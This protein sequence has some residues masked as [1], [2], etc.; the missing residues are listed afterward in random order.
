MTKADALYPTF[1]N[2]IIW[3]HAEAASA[4]FELGEQDNARQLTPKGRNQAK[5]MARWLEVHLPKN[6]VLL[7]SPALRAV[8]TAQALPYKTQLENA[9]KPG[10]SLFEV[11]NAFTP[12]Q[13]NENILIVGHQP[14]L[15]ELVAY[16]LTQTTTDIADFQSLSIQSLGIQSLSIKKSAVCWLRRHSTETSQQAFY[17]LHSLQTPSLL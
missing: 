17:K 4:D 6:T 9:L 1:D 16:L 3:R 5:R 12:Y 13:Q 7:S 14:W 11:L 8:Q 15:G 10:A 2:I